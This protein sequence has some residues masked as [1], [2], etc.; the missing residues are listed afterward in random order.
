MSLKL[1]YSQLNLHSSA[2]HECLKRCSTVMQ[3]CLET[4]DDTLYCNTTD[5]SVAMRLSQSCKHSNSA[6][7]CYILM[8]VR[9]S[10]DVPQL[11]KHAWKHSMIPCIVP[12]QGRGYNGFGEKIRF[13]GRGGKGNA[14]G[15]N[16]LKSVASPLRSGAKRQRK[17]GKSPKSVAFKAGK[18]PKRQRK[19]GKSA[20]S[21]ASPP[22][23]SPPTTPLPHV[24]IN[25]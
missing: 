12:Y 1:F 20:K 7:Q 10:N 8:F 6:P 2:L 22:T 5:C 25:P 17:W 3:A 16:P 15:G 4:Y 21:A 9:V 11:C 18:K 14:N 23:S 24:P 13:W 19:W